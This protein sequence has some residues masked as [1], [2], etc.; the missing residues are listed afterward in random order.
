[1]THAIVAVGMVV[2]GGILLLVWLVYYPS[3]D[4]ALQWT[5]PRFIAAVRAQ[6]P[7]KA[8]RSDAEWWVKRFE[9]GRRVV[10][11]ALPSRDGFATYH[12]EVCEGFS[13]A[14]SYGARSGSFVTPLTRATLARWP[15]RLPAARAHLLPDT[16][17]WVGSLILRELGVAPNTSFFGL[18][19]GRPRI[20]RFK[21]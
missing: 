17:C 18:E 3:I 15:G 16:P 19:G 9:D 10:S 5:A 8:V 2:T 7:P 14:E 21:R 11:C 12:W 20:R 1:M 13:P 4:D 6:P